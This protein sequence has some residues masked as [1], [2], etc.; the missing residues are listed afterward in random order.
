MNGDCIRENAIPGT[1]R[2]ETRLTGRVYIQRRVDLL[3]GEKL[4]GLM[5]VY[6]AVSNRGKGTPNFYLD[7]VGHSDLYGN[8]QDRQY[9]DYPFLSVFEYAKN[10]L[11]NRDVYPGQ[12]AEIG[13]RIKEDKSRESIDL[14]QW[15][16]P[17]IPSYL[18]FFNNSYLNRVLIV[19]VGITR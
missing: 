13:F 18:A 6:E 9:G 17:A 5:V 16:K 1:V 14:Y 8:G 19:T 2:I 11:P 4:P 3:T 12:T 15:V 10:L 7:F